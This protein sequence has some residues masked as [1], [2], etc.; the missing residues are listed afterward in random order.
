M[1]AA[2]LLLS[3]VWGAYSMKAS[4]FAAVALLA[5]AGGC[6]PF[7][8]QIDLTKVAPAEREASINVRIYNEGT[9]P[10]KI[11]KSVGDVEA[12]S[13]KHLLTDPPAS[14]GNAL[15]QLRLKAYRLGADAVIDVVFDTRGTDAYGTN[16]WETV[17]AAGVAVVTQQ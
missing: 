2:R 5:L 9:P 11:A 3:L 12:Y 8:E 16:C 6:A 15:Q 10:P 17:H 14:R 1:W 7:V 4:K 13:C